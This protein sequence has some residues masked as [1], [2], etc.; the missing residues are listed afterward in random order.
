LAHVT[1]GGYCASALKC[2]E[3]DERLLILRSRSLSATII[4][5]N[6]F[7]STLPEGKKLAK[8]Y[9]GE[10]VALPEKITAK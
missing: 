8:K 2:R 4:P 10:V 3:P 1:G 6:C 5:P 7:R 9:G